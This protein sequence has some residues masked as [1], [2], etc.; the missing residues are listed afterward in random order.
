MELLIIGLPGWAEIVVVLFVGLLLFGR[1]LPEVGRSLGKTIVEFK[2]GGMSY[3]LIT[4]G[5]PTT[6]AAHIHCGASGTT[7]PVGVTLFV[8]ALTVNGILAQGPIVAPDA[9]N[10]C[11]WG[12]IMDV[13][14]AIESGDTY[15]NVHTVQNM[16]MGDIRGQ[17]R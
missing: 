10:L 12:D 5:L 8:G 16:F 14:D 3:K 4:A 1:R 9:A 2:K 6:V 17:L 7:G 15:V 11:G 13:R